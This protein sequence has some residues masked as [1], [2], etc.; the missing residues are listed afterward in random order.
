[1]RRLLV[2]GVVATVLGSLVALGHWYLV[3]R[4][5]LDPQLPAPLPTLLGGLAVLG[6]VGLWAGLVADAALARPL[7]RFLGWPG[8]VWMGLWF[9]ATAL[10][11]LSDLVFWLAGLVGA[12]WPGGVPADRIRAAAVAGVVLLASGLGMA[13]A[14]SA[15]RLVRVS[16]ALPRW[17]AALD[18][19]R[20]AFVC[21]L[22]VGALR[23]RRFLEPIVD[24]VLALDADL[25][26]LGGDLVDGPVGKRADEVASL[27][28]LT[29]PDGVRM[30]TGNHE[31]I[32]GGQPWLDHLAG[33][34]IS[35][36]ANERVTIDRDGAR[37]DLAGVHDHSG[38]WF[39][40]PEDLDAALAGRDPELPVIL[41]AHDPSSWRAASEA[42]VDLQL[43]GHTHGGQV[44]PFSLLVRL[45]VGPVAGLYR[46]GDSQFY[47]SR[48]TGFWGPPMRLG[49][50][51]EITELTIRRALSPATPSSPTSP[52]PGTRRTSATRA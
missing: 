37:F 43:S 24:R 41:L 50:P 15:P 29:A 5:A 33:L 25:V 4:L 26:A 18:G 51:A 32:S 28:R 48:G 38:R 22:H 6:F 13:G 36:L 9:L 34:G 49:A 10:L 8:A 27:A 42:G 12:D 14:L 20:I 45:F 3:L 30:C 39:G 21:D 7:A 44:W 16:L 17:P 2:M 47:V 11:G 1:M 19:Y 40:Y 23:G 52:R 35:I 31:F 46:R